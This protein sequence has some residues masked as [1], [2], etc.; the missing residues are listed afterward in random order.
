MTVNNSIKIELT[1]K[2]FVDAL[3]KDWKRLALGLIAGMAIPLVPVVTLI[4]IFMHKFHAH[5]DNYN[6]PLHL[7]VLVIIFLGALYGL[8]YWQIRRAKKIFAQERFFRDS[9]PVQLNWSA[10]GK[11]TLIFKSGAFTKDV[12]PENIV[13]IKENKS[14]ILLFISVMHAIIIPKRFFP[15][16]ETLDQFH[17][18]L[19]KH[20]VK[21]SLL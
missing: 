6:I 8:R 4:I 16:K 19:A 11:I 20:Y 9:S 14:A 1:E 15:E 2:D 7:L 18:M 17:H 5:V 10:D 3:A 12:L 13:K 21:R